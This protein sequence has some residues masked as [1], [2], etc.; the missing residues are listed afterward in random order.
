M[1]NFIFYSL[2]G[3]WT[4]FI[5]LV[6]VNL[7]LLRQF[8]VLFE[9]VAPAGALAMNAQLKTGDAAPEMTLTNLL[10]ETL[11]IGAPQKTHSTEKT[12]LFFLSPSCVVCK[13]LLP[14]VKQF[15][16]AG[17]TNVIYASAGDDVQLHEDFIARHEL[18]RAQYLISDQLGM[19]YGVSKLP[20]AF[21]I[22]ETGKI[23]A[24]GL[25]NTREHIE[26]L[27]EANEMKVA[28]LQEYVAANKTGEQKD[29]G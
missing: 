3:L 13:T 14:V 26:S 7:A 6:V 21:L 20:Y 18:P 17:R 28:S 16:H 22:D 11:S 1:D 8:G 19:I 10:G 25:V 12:L 23:S 29:V 5:I 24:M 9:R 4:G 2:I 27:F 15:T